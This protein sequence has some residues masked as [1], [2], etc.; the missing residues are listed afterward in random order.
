MPMRRLLWIILSI[1]CLKIFLG[2]TG[3]LAASLALTTVD[4]GLSVPGFSLITLIAYTLVGSILISSSSADRRAFHLGG[5]FLLIASSNADRLFAGL[6][7]MQIPILPFV[8]KTLYRLQPDSFLPSFLWLFFGEFPR[9]SNLGIT[10]AIPRRAVQ[11]CMVLGAAIFL[12]LAFEMQLPFFGQPGKTGLPVHNLNLYVFALATTLSA[13]LPAFLFAARSSRNAPIAEKRRVR[14][15]IVGIGIGLVPHLIAT[16]LE[17]IIPQ[18]ARLVREPHGRMIESMILRP[19]LILAAATT[20]YS[21]LVNRILDVKLYIRRA[22]QYALAR[23][24]LIVAATLPFL[25]FVFYVYLNRGK[26]VSGLL[27]DFHLILPLVAALSILCLPLRSKA[28]HLI[29]RHFFREQYDSRQ[30]LADLI[31]STRETSNPMEMALL[32]TNEINR[33]LHLDT[34]SILYRLEGFRDLRCPGGTVSPLNLSWLLAVLLAG[35]HDPLDVD[36]KSHAG[37][38]QR[39]SAEEREWLVDGN[40]SLLVPL[41]ASDKSLIG[42]IGLG[43]KKERIAFFLGGPGSFGRYSLGCSADH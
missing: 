26:T 16:V 36:L 11:F 15:F 18:F 23:Y 10:S 24:T 37:T 28:N 43:E 14:L 20:A 34:I 13:I 9:R 12:L 8:A 21:V 17:M 35:S 41:L 3:F 42:L 29:D 38:L 33:A 25:I 30:I 27:T 40:F 5:A 32:L 1:A 19:L 6:S 31:R 39:L 7:L 22:V 4:P 2:I